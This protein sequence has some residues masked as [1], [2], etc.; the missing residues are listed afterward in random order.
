M[1]VEG[2]ME[3]DDG[4]VDVFVLISFGGFFGVRL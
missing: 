4:H 2:Q 1:R 3:L